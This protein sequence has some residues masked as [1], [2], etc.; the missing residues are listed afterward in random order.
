MYKSIEWDQTGF[1]RLLDQRL[2]PQKIEYIE[3]RDVEQLAFAIKDMMIR[4]APAIGVT[5]AYGLALGAVTAPS[6][7]L[8]S[9]MAAVDEAERILKASRPTAVNLFWALDEVRARLSKHTIEGVEDYREKL[10]SIATDM[11]HEDGRINRQIGQNALALL[12]DPVTFIH[13]CNT[14]GL[15]TVEYGTALGVI[16]AAHESGRKVFVYVSE[17][18]PRLQGAK[19]TA[20]EL[21][22]LGIPHTV[23]VDG[24]TGHFMK[25]GK[26][27]ACVVGCD[28]VARNGDTA[29]KIGTYNLAV[30]A[31]AHDIP[32]YVA[33]PTSTIDMNTLSGADIEIENR[34]AEEVSHI[35]GI[36]IVPE[37]TSTENP[38]FDIT[39]AHLVTRFLT[40]KGIA[41][42]PYLETFP[43][44]C[45][46]DSSSQNSPNPSWVSKTQSVADRIRK[47]GFEYVLRNNGGYLSQICST[48]EIFAVLYTKIMHLGGSQ[49]PRIPIAFPGTPGKGNADYVNGGAYNGPA[50]PEFDKFIFSPAHYALALYVALIE[51]DRMDPAGLEAFNQ[52]GSTVELIGAEHSPGIET[53]TGSL[54]QAL[55][56][57]G[58]MAL[59]RKLKGDSGRVW[60]MMSDGEFQEGQTW[61]AV[62]ALA[63]HKLDTVRVIVDCNGQ[64]CDGPMNSVMNI[65]PLRARLESFGARAYDVD[66]H[67]IEAMHALSALE[68]DGRPLFILART[69]PAQGIPALKDRAPLMHYLRFKDDAERQK[70]EKAYE[71]HYGS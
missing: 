71:E 61:E 68:P 20:W 59:G 29:N 17:T 38:A 6:Q 31:K 48:A 47:R 13:H 23:I 64:Q 25:T 24:A 10:V 9:V 34:D 11:A 22:E 8:P 53:T 14:G 33:A 36:S 16:R 40:E 7:D 46:R 52:D 27:D 51:V 58:G 3:C 21:K 67:D 55:S 41:Q 26:I 1:V 66:G 30:M 49:A 28:R 70:F 19:L 45:A 35:N 15:A 44:L 32:F 50:G 54:A 39:P 37:G 2:L 12:P 65:E 18:R 4:G 63:F 57:A 69:N 62:S 60:V 43:R 5:A 42:A 56:Q